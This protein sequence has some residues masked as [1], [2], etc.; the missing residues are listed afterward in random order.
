V[1]A[2]SRAAQAY[3]RIES[4]SRSPLE[5]VVML[6]DGALRFLGDARDAAARGDLRARGKAI[7]RVLAIMSELQNTLDVE[8]G[9]AVAEQLDNLYTYMVSRL[10]DV[11]LTHDVAAIDEVYKL[12]VPIREAWGQIASQPQVLAQATV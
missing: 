9:G 3:R 10:I 12:L 11:T 4:E 8:Q 6:Y 7:S 1:I 2:A 5:L